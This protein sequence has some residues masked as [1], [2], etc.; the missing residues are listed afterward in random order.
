M[1]V[2]LTFYNLSVKLETRDAVLLY[3]INNFLDKYY[4]IKIKG[5][6]SNISIE[7]R[8]FVSKIKNKGIYYL[9][10]NQFF[11]LYNYLNKLN[12]QLTVED[13]IDE[14]NYETIF[15]NMTVRDGWKL[16]EKQV[17]VADFILN[18][19][20]GSKLI[21]LSTGSG[22]TFISLYSI[23][24]LKQRLAIV[25]LPAYIDKWVNDIINIHNATTTDVMTIQGSKEVRALIY[26][27]KNNELK[28]NYYIFSNRTLSEYIKTYEE[29]PDLCIDMYGASPIDLFPLL[30]IG[31]LLIDETH[32][33]FYSIFKILLYSNV[34]FHLGLSATLMSDENVVRRVHKIVYPNNTVYGDTMIKK[35]IDVYP[36]SYVIP[37]NLKKFFR[38]NTYGSK[39]YS[40]IAFE[41]SIMRKQDLAERYY[42]IID[43]VI[44]DYYISEYQPKDKLLIFIATVQ[45]ATQLTDF[46][47][48]K[49]K[50]KIVNRYCEDDPYENLMTSDIII[51]TVLSSGTAVDIPHLRVIIHTV[52]IL[53]SVS[54]LQALGRLRELPDRDVKFCYLYSDNI[55]KQKIYHMRRVELFKDRVA[56]IIYRRSRVNF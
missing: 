34:K 2:K 25:I 27:A 41:Q 3:H 51:S 19:P 31:V 56:N 10:R 45:M 9:H 23:A 42:K 17:P 28:H 6:S 40:H 4:T 11:H 36:I 47:R 52:S 5:F 26:L 32:Q 35:Y 43:G 30:G 18:N 16:R 37:D 29:N 46:L 39:N 13:K 49:Y 44:Q 50:D 20:T 14:R 21:P 54:N 53:S 24:K 12:Y 33:H 15:A 38:T 48:E 55:I 8:V 1:S 7:D 22:K